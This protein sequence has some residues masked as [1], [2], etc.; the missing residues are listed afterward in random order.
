MNL[1]THTEHNPKAPWNEIEVNEPETVTVISNL[2]D[3]FNSGYE[4]EFIL[5]QVEAMHL[6]NEILSCLEA[7]ES[8]LAGKM[9]LL[10]KKLE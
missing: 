3:A 10:I 7:T 1:D 2:T 8:G 6:A 4:L 9:R 5:I